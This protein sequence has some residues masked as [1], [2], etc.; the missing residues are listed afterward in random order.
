LVRSLA[1]RPAA[2]RA[3]AEFVLGPV[4]RLFLNVDLDQLP[5]HLVTERPG[6]GF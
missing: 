3:F 2:D 1:S 6:D 5:G 4:V